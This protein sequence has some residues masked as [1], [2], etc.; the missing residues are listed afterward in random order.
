MPR[1]IEPVEADIRPSGRRRRAC[2][3]GDLRALDPAPARRDIAWR[4]GLGDEIV[5]ARQRRTELRNFME[6]WVR[7][8][9]S[10][11]G[12]AQAFLPDAAGSSM[13]DEP[14]FYGSR[15]EPTITSTMATSS[16]SPDRA[17]IRTR[18]PVAMP[19]IEQTTIGQYKL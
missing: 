4:P 7:P 2:S 16:L 3:S 14:V 18:T 13:A 17:E 6:N 1:L 19:S 10:A 9:K 5:D 11:R 12:R 15:S 8:E